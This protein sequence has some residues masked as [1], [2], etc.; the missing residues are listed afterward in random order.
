MIKEK[1]DLQYFFIFAYIYLKKQ[2][3]RLEMVKFD[4]LSI[5]TQSIFVNLFTKIIVLKIFLPLLLIILF[6]RLDNIFKKNLVY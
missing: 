1:Y 2:K 6:R 4:E 3:N 5:L